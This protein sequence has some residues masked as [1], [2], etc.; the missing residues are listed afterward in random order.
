MF[1]GGLNWETNDGKSQNH[2]MGLEDT[3]NRETT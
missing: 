3:L 2:D 1:I